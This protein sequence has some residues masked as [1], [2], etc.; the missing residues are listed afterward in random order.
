[1]HFRPT[2]GSDRFALA[3]TKF[4]RLFADTFFA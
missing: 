3:V 2:G 1:V 4:L